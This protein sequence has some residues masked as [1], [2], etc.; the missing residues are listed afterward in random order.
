MDVYSVSTGWKSLCWPGSLLI[1]L[2][3]IN[4]YLLL[5]QHEYLIIV[6]YFIFL[7][8]ILDSWLVEG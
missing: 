3:M 5:K 6:A 4:Y 2:Q 8:V 7:F 1:F